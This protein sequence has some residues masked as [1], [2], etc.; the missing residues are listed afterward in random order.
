MDATFEHLTQTKSD[1]PNGEERAR[2]REATIERS[3]CYR[4]IAPSMG[5][6][7]PCQGAK[8]AFPQVISFTHANQCSPLG[9]DK[10]QP[11]V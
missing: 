5:L 2:Q 1:C 4:S 11:L 10:S 9:D 6:G 7:R 3:M 8:R